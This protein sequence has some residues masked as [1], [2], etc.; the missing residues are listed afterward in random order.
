[1]FWGLKSRNQK[2][3][4]SS[5]Y[6]SHTTTWLKE[7][8]NRATQSSE[9]VKVPSANRKEATL[10]PVFLVTQAFIRI[11]RIFVALKLIL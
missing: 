4:W 1:M 11:L 7:V 5:T 10:R 2:G 9:H 6:Y 3:V 8:T